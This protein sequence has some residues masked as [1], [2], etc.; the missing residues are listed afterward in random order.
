MANPKLRIDIEPHLANI[1]KEVSKYEKEL[2]T[3][4]KQ[5]QDM[6]FG[7]NLSKDI[8]ECIDK[9]SKLK[10]EYSDNIHKL[11]NQKIDTS[12]FDRFSKEMESRMQEL[13]VRINEVEHT[14]NSFSASIKN[15]NVSNLTRQMSDIKTAFSNFK[16]DIKG[17]VGILKD[18]QR[19]TE[20]SY[21]GEELKKYNQAIKQLG[22]LNFENPL[23]TKV[24]KKEL[25]SLENALESLYDTY[26]E[27][28]EK[29]ERT[30]S[31][32]QLKNMR[33]QMV[34]MLT[35]MESYAQKIAKIKGISI[36]QI[37]NTDYSIGKTQTPLADIA[38]RIDEDARALS[39]TLT[40]EAKRI[41][42][43]VETLASTTA[44]SFEFKDGGI[45]IPVV[46]D[47]NAFGKIRNNLD[48]LVNT[49]N[50]ES[51]NN[52]V[53]VTLRLF[54]L[55][56]SKS[57]QAE[58]SKYINNVRAQIPDLPEGEL[59]DNLGK[60]MDQFEKEYQKALTLKI[61]VAFSDDVEDVE[62]KIELI[63]KAAKKANIEINPIFTVT[64]EEAKNL[65]EQLDKM[66]DDFG[67]DF[68]EK[69]T[70]MADSLNRLLNVSKV[71][72]W[73][74][75]FN[76]GLSNINNKLLGMKTLIAP[77]SQ[78]YSGSTNKRKR[79]RPSKESIENQNILD[80]F[81]STMGLLNKTLSE[82]EKTPKINALDFTQNIQ[83][84]ID[85][86]N[87]PVQ[88]PV[89]PNIEGF[90]EQLESQLTDI[91][92]NINIGQISGEQGTISGE[93]S[94]DISTAKTTT[95]EKTSK[96]QN[97][98]PTNNLDEDFIRNE[99]KNVV[100]GNKKNKTKIPKVE[101][102]ATKEF[103]DIYNNY[104]NSLYAIERLTAEINKSPSNSP[105]LISDS[106]KYEK[107]LKEFNKKRDK[108]KNELDEVG[109]KINQLRKDNPFLENIT[110]TRISRGQRDIL[111]EQY[112]NNK[113]IK[114][115]S[116]ISSQT[117]FERLREEVMGKGD[118]KLNSSEAKKQF[119]EIL[120]KYAGYK[121]KGGE[122]NIRDLTDNPKAQ[123]KLID[124][125]N[126]LIGVVDNTTKTKEKL[127]EVS[128]QVERKSEYEGISTEQLKKKYLDLSKEKEEYSK[129]LADDVIS[130]LDTKE[131][132]TISNV[133][134]TIKDT[135][136][137][138]RQLRKNGLIDAS[139]LSEEQIKA[140]GYKLNQY[141]DAIDAVSKEEY[142]KQLKNMLIGKYG[143]SEEYFKDINKLSNK[144]L[145][146]LAK[147]IKAQSK[148][149][150]LTNLID[151]EMNK[152]NTE[153]N[154]REEEKSKNQITQST[155]E[156][157]KNTKAKK[158][159]INVQ[160]EINDTSN[161]KS[162]V[163]NIKQE[164]E[165]INKNTK[166]KQTNAKVTRDK[167]GLTDQ[168]KK[169]AQ[170]ELEKT[171]K[172][173]FQQSKN[174]ATVQREEAFN[175][176][177]E[178]V[179]SMGNIDTRKKGMKHNLG[180]AVDQYKKYVD[181][182]G[183]RPITDLSDNANAQK[184]LKE[185]YEKTT[186]AIKEQTSE[187][188]KNNKPVVE[189]I[190][191]EVDVRQKN[192]NVAKEETDAVNK[193]NQAKEKLS[194]DE[195]IKQSNQQ[196]IID[197]QSFKSS[198][199]KY[200]KLSDEYV[201]YNQLPDKT[202]DT[203]SMDSMLKK[204]SEAVK[205]KNQIVKF[206][207]ENID[208]ITDSDIEKLDNLNS[209][210]G[211]IIKGLSNVDYTSIVDLKD[212]NSEYNKAFDI[213]YDKIE[214]NSKKQG[215]S[216]AEGIESTKSQAEQ[217]GT[218]LA[219][220]ANEGT[221][222]AQQS[223][224]PSKVAEALG[225]D[226][227][228]GYANGI[229]KSEEAVRS[230][231]TKL[232]TDGILTAQDIIND[233]PNITS[234]EKL[235]DLVNPVSDFKST[236]GKASGQIKRTIGAITKSEDLSPEQL[237]KYDST[238]TK[239]ISIL[240]KLGVDVSEFQNSYSSARAKFNQSFKEQMIDMKTIDD[241][242]RQQYE[243]LKEIGRNY[244]GTDEVDLIQQ[245]RIDKNGNT[246]QSFK[247]S[248]KNGSVTLN[249]NGGIVTDRIPISDDYTQTQ[250]WNAELL[251]QR[252]VY[253][254]EILAKEKAIA[255]EQNKGNV[256]TTAELERQRDAAQKLYD[257]A[258]K[259]LEAFAEQSVIEEQNVKH[260]EARRKSENEINTILA[261][262]LDA[263]DK[264]AQ[265]EREKTEKENQKQ[266]QK[267]AEQQARTEIKA[268][269]QSE[270]ARKKIW[271]DF[272]KE[273]ESYEEATKNTQYLEKQNSLYKELEL[274]VQQYIEMRKRIAQGKAFENDIEDVEKLNND[275]I[276]LADNLEKS[277]Y[278]SQP[279]ENKALSG[280]DGLENS[281]LNIEQST[282]Q[283]DQDRRSK[284]FSGLQSRLSSAQYD[285]EFE[286]K[287]GNST[288]EFEET[289]QRILVDLQKIDD[290]SV[291]TISQEEIDRAEQLLEQVRQI[292]KQ[293]KL[294]S[295]RM[296]NENSVQKGLSQIN[297]ILSQ[298][299]K[300]S[301]K[302]T[303]VYKDLVSLQ[304]S[305][306]NF[307]TSRPQSELAELTT[308]LLKTKA[309][310]ED[311]DN[312]VKGK[313]LFQTFIE[314]LHGT[315]AQL[316]A[317]YLSW[318]DIIRYV[319]S[320]ATT[321]ID[322]DTQLVD[323]RKTTT[324][325]T[326]ELNEFYN[327]SSN[328]AKELGV[329]TSEIISQAAAWS[330]LGYS[331]K[332]AAT[333]MAEMSSKFAAISPGMTTDES[334]DYLVSTMQAYGIAVDDVERKILD[335]VNRIG[336]TFATTNA[337]IGEMLTRSSAAMKAANNSLEETIALESAA[338]EVTRN[339]ETTGT[340]FRTVSMRIRGLDEETEEA[341]EDYEEL[342]G[343]IADLTKTEKTPGG[344]SLFTDAS[345]TEYK[346]TYQFLK[347]I[348]EIWDDLTDKEQAGLLETIGGKRGAQSLAPILAN[349]DEVERAM[350]EME[351][352]AGAAD[353]EMGIIRDS[354][355]YKINALK[356]TWVGVLQEITDRG[357]IG[358]FVD[359][360]TTIS[361]G[362]GNIVS[363]LGL[364]K[365]AIIGVATVVG[366]QKLG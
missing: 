133:L 32:T 342:K 201:A 257:F 12:E 206:S 14:M 263:I 39:D 197:A 317:Q 261:H 84:E 152:I 265:K 75:S 248:G 215:E 151:K 183:T 290:V 353:A 159:N 357:D 222:D 344:V 307:N 76:E 70:K 69:I 157:Q 190:Q 124:G 171:R 295:N 271:N 56:T 88:V 184:K 50:K 273:A 126:K 72:D 34:S 144:N 214:E 44:S 289:L 174:E 275:I 149:N 345:K 24:D 86:A 106:E 321:I 117:Y 87:I 331:S 165:E 274:K 17:A 78:L 172:K 46:L 266:V 224:S 311:L 361:E 110:G 23:N 137:E 186:A 71:S 244:L 251:K 4:Q 202:Y 325:T 288:K 199:K 226:W 118:F 51:E 182:G 164:T 170:S 120:Q 99:F 89:E 348:S 243:F 284:I 308:E 167:F 26:D 45:K 319:R 166:A 140:K 330:R 38:S 83:K 316:V 242:Q 210:Y 10:D 131:I 333:E 362:L 279:L 192:V 41:K 203:E 360:L 21:G 283:K 79:G 312:T 310:F 304:N 5:A 2:K 239:W 150:E 9:L 111:L 74:D 145:Q 195:Q 18:F 138:A 318:M 130:D 154:F 363:N 43:K 116:K 155:E 62:R 115:T 322:L 355:E 122:Q 142:S 134:K 60:F 314:R 200:N 352:A 327:V 346:S 281:I 358:K 129:H 313:N 25:Q 28:Q 291:D 232:V 350:D 98:K 255:I 20:Q 97:N 340:A 112:L 329:T 286:I 58:V 272:Q 227:G 216:Y 96:E 277:K 212:I 228:T 252:D 54:P 141:G 354:L 6:G 52:P 240:Q 101:R 139:E 270:K 173:Q 245:S 22:R 64:P 328:V 323:L 161:N 175:A 276:E 343:K 168:Q 249:P 293:G 92:I 188:N 49:L 256:N 338:V 349:F 285:I 292:R 67:I 254:T 179:S 57:E 341:L 347:D 82:R 320:M 48:S 85:L 90:T 148:K 177:K 302:R 258:T 364:V 262:Q 207:K 109:K 47:E 160:K 42:D 365:T 246:L 309:R 136:K 334:T 95:K 315:T 143:V 13:S 264:Q 294:S 132:D 125:Y 103:W 180:L 298:N 189:E 108:Q 234:D 205:I 128:E 63:K 61:K 196:K 16:N 66:E 37:W 208:N 280:L 158:E 178:I 31:P 337:E 27:L 336:N 162:N 269:E 213:I 73:S 181:Q 55:K 235:K 287:N 40:N 238:F 15:M 299:T 229:L 198:N 267:D 68:D 324:M 278:F 29:S 326:G 231:I 219:N 236:Y 359:F 7:D 91:P 335:N 94:N 65:Q 339:A 80:S 53:F 233:L 114:K 303:D 220:A 296:A 300:S 169:D 104:M 356:Q 260:A 191:E 102:E 119:N 100:F 259:D 33:E 3:L 221:A 217:A 237:D 135:N 223:N 253:L 77:L 282:A 105:E 1:D 163:D 19:L 36:D 268:D 8:Q 366:S 127:V 35:E 30:T 250:K 113:G 187:K 301:F 204:R 121:A 225:G 59:K 194:I 185:A 332:E 230:A 305:F 297:S 93:I 211:E 247:V 147:N 218:D 81:T 146:D 209:K 123:K 193:S 351:G 107:Y 153:L 241:E 11:A 306:K 176:L 156:V